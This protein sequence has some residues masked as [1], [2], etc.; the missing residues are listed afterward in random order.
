[1]D[2]LAPMPAGPIASLRLQLWENGYEPIPVVAHNAPGKSPGKRPGVREW[3]SVTVDEVTILGWGKSALRNCTNTGIRCGL[4]RAVDIDVLNP[5]LAA[6]VRDVA[7]RL[8]GQ[9]SLQ[10]IGRA[11]KRLLCYRVL[12]PGPKAE[13]PEFRL[14]DGSKAQVE[15]LG[16]GQQFVAYGIHPET[17]AEYEWPE[18]GPDIVPLADLPILDPTAEKAFLAAAETLIR[19]AGGRPLKEIEAEQQASRE[20]LRHDGQHV[21]S[22]GGERASGSG[23]DFFRNV[24]SRAVHEVETWFRRLFPSGYWQANATTPPGAWRVQSADI[25]R[26]LEEDIS[27]HPVEG[28]YDF[29]TR[30]PVTPID[31]V[32][33]HGNA[34]S[35]AEAALILCE[36]IHVAPE[37]LGWRGKAQDQKGASPQP[38][39]ARPALIDPRSWTELPPPR[40]WIVPDWVPRGVVTGL[41]GDGAVGKSLAAMQL[42]TATALARP[43]FGLEVT[44]GRALGVFCEDDETELQRRQWAI[45]RSLGADA[46]QLEKLRYLARLGHDNALITFDGSDV[47]TPTRFATELDE[48]CG[49]FHPDL[50][51]LD[52]IADLFPANENDRAKVRQ[53]VQTILG[54]LARRHDCAVLALGHPSVTGMNSGT[55]Q[56]GSTAWNNTFRSRFYLAREDGENPDPD[57][58]VLSRKKANYAP[59][60]AEIQLKWHE[61]VFRV[62]DAAETR[63][64]DISWEQ[65]GVIF[66]EIARAWAEGRPW[67]HRPEARK[68]GR[69]LQVWAQRQLGVPEKRLSALLSDWIMNRFL[70]VEEVDR[71]SK[72]RGLRVLKRL[73]PEA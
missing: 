35:A 11:P 25:G 21:S 49:E 18:A 4:L 27:V 59:R 34:M 71:H 66:D 37:S 39:R 12:E 13:T 55:G 36:W 20:P 51:V 61:G 26:M 15:M 22:R 30:Q 57:A 31:L 8:L 5:A 54:G 6:S 24:N 38:P 60:D 46:S 29:G 44:P 19:E 64:S 28:G 1:M 42:L 58:R 7:L 33:Q 65:I 50:L 3:Q 53:F 43:W 40:T 67:S 2:G 32:M 62:P 63:S 72:M 17:A 68:N 9:T 10:R 69:M 41:Y 45:N 52:T 73:R 70:S 47:G 56:S 16:Q 48:L 14:P 23:G